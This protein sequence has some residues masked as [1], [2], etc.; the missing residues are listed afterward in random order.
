MPGLTNPWGTGV[1]A[2]PTSVRPGIP[3]GG[4]RSPRRSG[5]RSKAPDRSQIN[6]DR[7]SNCWAVVAPALCEQANAHGTRLS[8]R[9]AC[10]R[11]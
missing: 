8:N 3:W 1:S 6:I 10:S 9:R 4:P 2:C 5:S 7:R 11:N